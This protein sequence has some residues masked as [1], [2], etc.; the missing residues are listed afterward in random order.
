LDLSVGTDGCAEDPVTEK[1]PL[2]I[3]LISPSLHVKGKKEGQVQPGDKENGSWSNGDSPLQESGRKDNRGLVART[4]KGVLVSNEHK[5]RRSNG[6]TVSDAEQLGSD[7][8]VSSSPTKVSRLKRL[9]G[10]PSASLEELLDAE[11]PIGV[12]VEK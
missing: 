2:P 4:R 11:T 5:K 9:E 7:D 6:P 3:Q 8:T 1:C 12:Q 10:H